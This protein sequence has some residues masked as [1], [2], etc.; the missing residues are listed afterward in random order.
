MAARSDEPAKRCDRPQP[1]S[2]SAA[3]RRRASTSANTSMAADR[4]AAGVTSFNRP[5]AKRQHLD[6]KNRPYG[7]QRER[8]D[9]VQSAAQRDDVASHVHISVQHAEDDKDPGQHHEDDTGK[10]RNIFEN[11]QNIE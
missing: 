8:S 6:D 9:T 7:D 1:R 3:G 4:R 2:T 5:S 11:G 10:V